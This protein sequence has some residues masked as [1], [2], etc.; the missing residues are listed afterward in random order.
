MVDVIDMKHRVAAAKA[1]LADAGKQD[2]DQ[3]LLSLLEALERK[4]LRM[5]RENRALRMAESA[6]RVETRQL[7]KL[8]R[9]MLSLAE[10]ERAIAPGLAQDDLEHLIE[11]LDEIAAAAARSSDEPIRETK[12]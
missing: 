8:L 10:S 12:L 3:K 5:E 7:R 11:R 1:R 9:D 2:R 4:Y 6:A